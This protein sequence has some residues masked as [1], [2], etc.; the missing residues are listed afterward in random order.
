[1]SM[2]NISISID[3][4]NH[5]NV[6]YTEH[7]NNLINENQEQYPTATRRTAFNIMLLNLCEGES[8]LKKHLDKFI[9]A[10]NEH[11]FDMCRYLQSALSGGEQR[12]IVE[13]FE[14]D[15]KEEKRE[16]YDAMDA[17][18]ESFNKNID[19]DQQYYLN[20]INNSL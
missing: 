1:M 17:M 6:D 7:V 13:F 2:F 11:D 5:S 3:M 15:V 18:K 14:T 12:F 9:E 10:S 16:L 4:N 20:K 19:R 8:F